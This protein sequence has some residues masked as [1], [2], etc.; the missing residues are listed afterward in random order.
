MI[1]KFEDESGLVWGRFNANSL[2]EAIG[3][4]KYAF[5]IIREYEYAEKI[6]TIT[7]KDGQ[8]WIRRIK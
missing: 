3:M 4:F 7:K 1:Y 6:F 8:G 5:G 2:A